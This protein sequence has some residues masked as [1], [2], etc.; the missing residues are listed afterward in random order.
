MFQHYDVMVI[1]PHPDDPEFGAGGTIAQWT[2]D[3]K[4]VIYIICTNGNKGS[5]DPEM[6]PEKLS[7]IRK[8]E[9]IDAARILGVSQVIFLEHDDQ[10]LEDTADFRKEIVKYIRTYTPQIVIAPDPYRRYIWHRDHRITGQIVLDAVFPYARDRLAYPDFI[11]AGLEPHK[12][13]EVLLFGSESP[14]Y[15]INIQST[16]QLKISAL[17]C[18]KSQVGKFQP[19]WEENY[20]KMLAKNGEICNCEIAEAFYRV[21]L[22]P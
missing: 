19:G 3:G 2:A 4:T 17:N 22:P 5:E 18:H 13:K 6:T 8:E 15:Y 11:Q 10:T 12:V 16:F 21:T 14:N 20:K 1:A 7:D 9:Q